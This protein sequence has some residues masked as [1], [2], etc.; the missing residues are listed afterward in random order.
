MRTD[1][2]G[3]EI[4]MEEIEEFTDLNIEYIP[5][6]SI[7]RNYRKTLIFITKKTGGLF[8]YFLG[9]STFGILAGSWV[10]ALRI[11][12]LLLDISYYESEK[13]SSTVIFKILFPLFI[14]IVV[15]ILALAIKIV[16][17]N[18]YKNK[19]TVSKLLEEVYRHNELVN[20]INT[21]DQLEAAGNSINLNNRH[22]VIE[23]LQ[24]TRDDLVRSLKTEKILRNNPRFN[25]EQFSIDLTA[26]RA[27]QVSEQASEYGKILD[28]A[29]QIGV[30]VQQEM[31]KLQ[32]RY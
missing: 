17:R 14:L 22:K 5:R 2:E 8:L 4:T 13:I 19:K 12:G 31:K 32:D 21:L 7:L 1:L 11:S 25:P 28:E 10:S 23:A 24:I 18:Y 20:N 3:I 29:L 30:N 15:I 27:L 26:L 9:L 16:L 6:Y